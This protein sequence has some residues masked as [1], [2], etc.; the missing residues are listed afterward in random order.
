MAA[1]IKE[2]KI[3]VTLPDGTDGVFHIPDE[4]KYPFTKPLSP[5]QIQ[6]LWIITEGTLSEDIRPLPSWRIAELLNLRPS[7]VSSRV[8]TPL[9][10]KRLIRYDNKPTSKP[11]PLHPRKEEKVWSL[12]PVSMQ[13]TYDLLEAYFMDN[14]FNNLIWKDTPERS[15]SSY[16]HRIAMIRLGVLITL[17]RRIAEYENS[18]Q[19]YQD[20]GINPPPGISSKKEHEAILDS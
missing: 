12:N 1:M 19:W 20:H 6:C 18:L 3:N 7:N 4:I 11:N 8:T 9:E 2:F 5:A 15:I 10:K 16:K 17:E 14:H 13:T